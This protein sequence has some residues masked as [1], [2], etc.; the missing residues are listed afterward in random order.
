ME[1][2]DT[3]QPTATE[4]TVDGF[5][6]IVI[7]FFGAI[8]TAIWFLVKP[9]YFLFKG[10]MKR[11][12]T[13]MVLLVGGAFLYMLLQAHA[14]LGGEAATLMVSDFPA[15]LARGILGCIAYYA[16]DRY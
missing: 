11:T 14:A 5:F 15:R 1:A 7:A 9:V 8:G 12:L 4:K 10:D 2:L 6:A 13:L 3:A 16:I